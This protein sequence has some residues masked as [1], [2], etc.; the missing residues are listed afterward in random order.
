MILPLTNGGKFTRE[1]IILKTDMLT[2][3]IVLVHQ[4]PISTK[5]ISFP[6]LGSSFMP[7]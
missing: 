4:Q 7:Y 6:T 1:Y 2:Y 5:V 3:L